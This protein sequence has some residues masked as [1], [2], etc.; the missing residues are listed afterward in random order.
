[1]YR[2]PTC[3]IINLQTWLDKIESNVIIDNKCIFIVGDF[4]LP[5][6]DW[7]VPA[8]TNFNNSSALFLEMFSAFDMMQCNKL[9][10]R[11]DNLLDLCFTNNP[12]CIILAPF[13]LYLILTAM[14][15]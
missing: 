13:F 8:T 3:D 11:G 4:N 12:A 9:P 14:V 1:M 5:E 2:R 10:I 15:F 6:I 7:S